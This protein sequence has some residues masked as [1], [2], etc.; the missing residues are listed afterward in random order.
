MTDSNGLPSNHLL[1]FLVFFWRWVQNIC[2]STS[3]CSNELF[4]CDAVQGGISISLARIHIRTKPNFEMQ[5]CQI[6]TFGR[7]HRADLVAALH[8][9]ADFCSDRLQM[10]I[11]GLDHRTEFVS[12]RQAMGNQDHFAPSWPRATG[13]HHA[14]GSC[15]VNCIAEIGVSAA[16]AVQIVAKV[17]RDAER[18][19]IVGECAVFRPHGHVKT[20]GERQGG[21]FKRS[22]PHESRIE[23]R[24]SEGGRCPKPQPDHADDYRQE[25]EGQKHA[26]NPYQYLHE[27]DSM[28]AGAL[29]RER[30][31]LK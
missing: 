6:G 17:P 29:Q 26:H 20:G 19:G 31:A 16:D 15:R 13:I 23:R 18:P 24:E 14:P 9:L 2:S 4:G 22:Q 7:S 1:W 10:R 3:I 12:F 28:A 30:A 5:M 8:Q 25:G 21:D 11:H 27:G